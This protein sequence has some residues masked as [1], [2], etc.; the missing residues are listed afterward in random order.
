MTTD[1][2]CACR[3][4]ADVRALPNDCAPDLRTIVATRAA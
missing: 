2:A 1:V 3:T 4:V